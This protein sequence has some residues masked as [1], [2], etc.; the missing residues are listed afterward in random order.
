[1]QSWG[2]IEEDKSRIKAKYT[3]KEYK[4]NVDVLS[5]LKLNQF[6][7]KFKITEI[8]GYNM[9]GEWTQTDCRN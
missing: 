2:I 8:N 7:R 5:K 1:M 9:F 3:W 4:T 6:Y